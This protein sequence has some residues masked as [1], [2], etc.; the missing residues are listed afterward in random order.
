NLRRTNRT[1]S[2]VHVRLLRRTGAGS[3][4]KRRHRSALD[5]V[6]WRGTKR[7]ATNTGRVS[8]SEWPGDGERLCA[9]LRELQ[10]SFATE[11]DER[12]RRSHARAVAD[13]VWPLQLR[14]VERVQPSGQLR[15]GK[16]KYA[17]VPRGQPADADVGLDVDPHCERQQRS[18]VQLEP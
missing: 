5:H 4:E 2:D 11:R 10:R 8:A 14:A 12:P 15:S 3:A 9:V 6:P 1:R 17:R 13:T 16:Y 18:P 7:P